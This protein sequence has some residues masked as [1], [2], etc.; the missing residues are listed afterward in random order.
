MK[1][2]LE[3]KINEAQ[4]R[5][6]P[7][8]NPDC[9]VAMHPGEVKILVSPAVCTHRRAKSA[10]ART[11]DIDINLDRSHVIIRHMPSTSNSP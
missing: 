9:N 8:P 6:I 5:T 3:T 1:M 10:R 2:Y 7:C 4:V 11:S